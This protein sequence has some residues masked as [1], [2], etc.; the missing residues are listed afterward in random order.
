M[1]ARRVLVYV[2]ALVVLITLALVIWPVPVHVGDWFQ[3]WYAGHIT[4]AG[5][6]PLSIATWRDAVYGYPE[7][8]DGAVANARREIA[9]VP[10]TPIQ[11]PV[12][13]Y[14]P[15]TAALFIPFGV[16]PVVAGVV[17]MHVTFVVIGIAAVLWLAAKLALPAPVKALALAVLFAYEPW[18]MATR[19]GHFSAVLLAGALVTLV[20]LETGSTS[21]LVAGG[22]LLSLKP[23]VAFGFG[24]LVLLY[25]VWQRD[26]RRILVTGAVL[27]PFAIVWYLRYPPPSITGDALLDRITTDDVAS[28]Y[29]LFGPAGG[30]VAVA[31]LAVACWWVVRRATRYRTLTFAACA[32]CLSLAVSPYVHTYDHLLAAPAMLLPLALVADARGA[33]RLGVGIVV[34][35][36]ALL[37]PWSA[38]FTDVG[39]RQ[40]P[41]GIVPFVAVALLVVATASGA[42]ASAAAP[43]SAPAAT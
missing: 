17:A 25:L 32:L 33:I 9:T 6:N 18:V 23:H 42:R 30:V 43:S 11:Y 39:A 41:S 37:I 24:L 1:T 38:Y 35:A 16:L 3:W 40:A 5:E 4:A 28:T 36:G 2:P 12:W 14:P 7:I 22:F 20:A 15:W 19:T 10:E 13:V 26:W 31:L 8:I 27:V 21:A 34:I 29:A